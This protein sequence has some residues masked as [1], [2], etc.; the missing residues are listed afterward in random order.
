MAGGPAPRL[1]LWQENW[2]SPRNPKRNQSLR[3][4]LIGYKMACNGGENGAEKP[5]F[6]DFYAVVNTGLINWVRFTPESMRWAASPLLAG[7]QSRYW[8]GFV[9][10]AIT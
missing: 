2:H 9:W 4:C 6:L 3:N 7:A 8:P 1:P 10:V 5:L